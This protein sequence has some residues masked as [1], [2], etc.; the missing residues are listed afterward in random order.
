M[1]GRMGILGTEFE[2]HGPR[3]EL[4]L[5]KRGLALSR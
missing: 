4:A 2:A 3:V 1:K 5:E